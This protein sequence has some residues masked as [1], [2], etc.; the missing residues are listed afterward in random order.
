[1]D[2][3]LHHRIGERKGNGQKLS[4]IEDGSLSENK[5]RNTTYAF[6]AIIAIAVFRSTQTTLKFN[7]RI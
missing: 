7:A 1:M 3:K 6:P 2:Q 5:F 4:E